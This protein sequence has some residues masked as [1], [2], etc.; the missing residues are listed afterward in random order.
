MNDLKASVLFYRQYLQ[1][2]KNDPAVWFELAQ[3]RREMGTWGSR[4]AALKARSYLKF[5]SADD[6]TLESGI[7]SFLGENKRALF[8]SKRALS[9]QS[10]I[11]ARYVDTAGLYNQLEQP[12]FTLRT[13]HDGLNINPA[14]TDLRRQ[15]A[16][17]NIQQRHFIKGVEELKQLL[18]EESNPQ[19][20]A[21][22]KSE[23]AYAQAET[24]NWKEAAENFKQAAEI[25]QATP[26]PASFGA[27]AEVMME[28]VEPT[29]I[30]TDLAKEGVKW[31]NAF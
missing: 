8:A 27:R 18:R 5:T 3:L 1:K 9:L 28:P 13:T 26:Q 21:E 11:P 14:S 15:T 10:N 22:I 25:L 30:P 17:A 29:A 19:T 6:W 16:T 20:I 24:G 7:A 12:Q 4:E 31:L 2:E 23:A